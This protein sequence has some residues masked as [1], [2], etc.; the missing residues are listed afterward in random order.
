MSNK[1]KTLKWFIFAILTFFIFIVLQVPAA[2]LI[3]KFYKNNQ[4]LHNVSGNVW[5]GSADWKKGN[6]Q[7]SLNWQI[8]PLDLLL[9]RLGAKVD[10]HS[11]NTELS[12]VMGYGLNKTLTVK[13]LEGQL[14]PET[15][16]KMADWQWPANPIQLQAVDFKYK[17]QQGFNQVTGQMQWAGGELVYSFA[18]RQ[19]RMNV[20]ALTGQLRD[21]SGQLLLDVRDSRDQR[22][23]NIKLDPAL[24]LD[25]QLTQRFLLNA[26]SYTGKAGLDS[27]VI[28][29]RQPLM[30]GWN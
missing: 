2:W 21:E 9:L 8:R 1:P 3:S 22:M 16:K 11:G 26:P 15:L 6:L 28:S 17:K 29:T 19:E 4:V 14:A 18:Q 5:Q 7:G 12:G 27:Y 24:M 30:R 10:L 20:P 23:L 25:I 13:N